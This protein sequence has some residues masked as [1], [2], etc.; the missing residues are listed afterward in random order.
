MKNKIAFLLWSLVLVFMVGSTAAGDDSRM[1]LS[2]LFTTD[3]RSVL[4]PCGT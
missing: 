4:L 1:T 3:T 2:I